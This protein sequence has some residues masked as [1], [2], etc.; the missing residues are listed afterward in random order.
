MGMA[1]FSSRTELFEALEVLDSYTKGDTSAYIPVLT[2]NDL[3][4]PLSEISYVEDP[5]LQ[6]ECQLIDESVLISKDARVYYAL[7]Y[8][9]LIPNKNLARMMNARAE[10]MVQDTVYKVSSRGTYFFPKEYLNSFEENYASLENQEGQL[11]SDNLYQLSEHIFRYNTFDSDEYE[12][13][14]VLVPENPQDGI[15]TKGSVIDWGDLINWEQYPRVNISAQSWIGKLFEG[16]IGRNKSFTYTFSGN[17]KRLKSKFYYFNYVFYSESGV[18]SKTEERAFLGWKKNFLSV[19]I[20]RKLFG[21][22]YLY[23]LIYFLK[24]LRL[25]LNFLLLY[26]HR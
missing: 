23:L 18:Y 8:D 16:L 13:D 11:V 4:V 7:G 20:F 17:K 19:L 12:D 3:F 2:E 6:V 21:K 22:L 15:L 5:V 1:T 14:V 26:L 9:E 10:I 25:L 24:I